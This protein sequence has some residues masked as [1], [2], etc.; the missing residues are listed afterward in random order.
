[1]RSTQDTA[2]RRRLVVIRIWDSR[3]RNFCS[4]SSPMDILSTPWTPTL[5]G[6]ACASF[7]LYEDF[8]EEDPI[9]NCIEHTTWAESTL[10]PELKKTPSG[11]A[12]LWEGILALW[13]LKT[14]EENGTNEESWR[15]LVSAWLVRS[16]WLILMIRL[17]VQYRSTATGI[18]A[19]TS[20]SRRLRPSWT[21]R[22]RYVLRN[23]S[24]LK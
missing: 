10:D 8:I 14:Y 13:R 11:R 21:T 16:C 5:R 19:G 3:S 9:P 17:T 22:T 7:P 4:S 2:R 20:T 6:N 1:V 18:F 23:I 12:A 15:N 24:L